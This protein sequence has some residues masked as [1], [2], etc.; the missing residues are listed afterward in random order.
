MPTPLQKQKDRSRSQAEIDIEAVTRERVYTGGSSINPNGGR[1]GDLL[2]TGQLFQQSRLLSRRE[3]FVN[4]LHARE[5]TLL[6]AL[7]ALISACKAL[8]I[9]SLTTK[10]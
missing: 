4:L 3:R 6:V 7:P 9:V 1:H 10:K 2:V 5:D 8:D